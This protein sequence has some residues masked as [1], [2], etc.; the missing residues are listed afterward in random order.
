MA[1]N[2]FTRS[3]GMRLAVVATAHLKAGDLAQSLALGHRSV[4][5]LQRV[6]SSKAPTTLPT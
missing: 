5:I 1:P 4:D 2:A 6:D 3:M